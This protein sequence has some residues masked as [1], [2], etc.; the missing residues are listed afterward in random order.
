MLYPLT[1]YF[2]GGVKVETK[3]NIQSIDQ[4]KVKVIVD[5][6]R[7]NSAKGK[8][9]KESDLLSEPISLEE[10][11]INEYISSI[12]SSTEYLDIVE[13][14]G[15][16]QKYIYSNK[17][18]TENY[19]KMIFRIEENDLLNLIVETI[20]RDS[21]IYPKPTPMHIFTNHPFNFSDNMLNSMFK[22]IVEE[23]DYKDIEKTVA[24]NGAVYLFSN[25]HLTRDHAEALT[26]WIEVLRF[27][28]P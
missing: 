17:E 27:E 2:V 6:I 1:N 23:E 9:I 10:S 7:V 19:A 16:Q 12:K 24:S 14:N 13:L 22:Q 4:E 18:M 8:F 21:K 28:N 11:N 3:E 15:K 20:R 5:Y 25:K 26:E